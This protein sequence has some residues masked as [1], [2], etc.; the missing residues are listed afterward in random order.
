MDLPEP[1]NVPIED[2]HKQEHIPGRQVCQ[3]ANWVPQ[4]AVELQTRVC[5]EVRLV[6]SG[7]RTQQNDKIER[8]RQFLMTFLNLLGLPENFLP[9]DTEKVS[10]VV[11]GVEEDGGAQRD[12]HSGQGGD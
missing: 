6:V 10:V 4:R 9:A 8:E 5:I 11:I 3:N 2:W 12:A 7:D 1:E